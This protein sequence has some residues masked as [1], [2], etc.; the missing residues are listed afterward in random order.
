MESLL[1]DVL[2]ERIDDFG[3]DTETV[4]VSV[5]ADTNGDPETV[6]EDAFYK[7]TGERL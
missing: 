1:I 6:I 7:A 4:N 3:V 5:D 2:L